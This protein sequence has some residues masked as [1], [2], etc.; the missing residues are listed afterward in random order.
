MIN[1]ITLSPGVTLRCYQDHRFKH[2][3]V[4]LQFVRPMCR[5]E[6]TLNALLPMVL[7]RGTRLHPNLQAITLHLDDLY[8]ASTGDMVRRIGDYQTTGLY[9]TFTEDRFAL[10]GDEIF[11]P[12]MAF[13]KELLRDPLLEDGI[14]STAIVESEKKNLIAD[15]EA[16]KNDRAAYAGSQL[17]KTMCREDSFSIPRLGEKDAVASITPQSLF[18]HYRML[19]RRAQVEIFYVGSLESTTVAKHIAPIFEDLTR[20]PDKLPGQTTFRDAGPAHNREKLDISQSRLC[21]GF[22]TA[23][24][25]QHKDF[26]AM[27]VLNCIFGAGMTSKLFMNIREKMSLCYSIGSG[28]YGGKGLVT[29]SAG[30]DAQKEETVRQEVLHQLQACANGQISQ[31]ELDAAKEAVLSSLRGVLDSP[32]AIEGYF[33]TAA[34]SGLNLTLEEYRRCIAGVTLEDV[35]RAAGSIT[36]H[37]D[38]F[39]E[40]GAK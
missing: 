31:E 27:Q 13:L 2:G 37:S 1:T 8:G 9:C 14:F 24:T 18:D 23:I 32:G 11:A 36:F 39:L 5:E 25:N 16:Q 30:I 3:R 20:E 21:M 22:T 35:C 38:F 10:E 7:L 40:G 15:L 34:L 26:P 33:S 28:Y 6:A 17:L 4:T 19:L 29:V 12:A